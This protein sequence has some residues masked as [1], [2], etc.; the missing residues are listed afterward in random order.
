MAPGEASHVRVTLQYPGLAATRLC[1][2]RGAVVTLNP[3][4]VAELPAKSVAVTKAG[5]YDKFPY[6]ISI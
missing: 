4:L 1:G 5:V 2:A 3:E 6:S